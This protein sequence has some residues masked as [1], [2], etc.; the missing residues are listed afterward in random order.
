MIV[1]Q[2]LLSITPRLH[3]YHV[4]LGLL[5]FLMRHVS[6]ALTQQTV[7][8][9][10]AMSTGSMTMEILITDARLDVRRWPVVLATRALIRTRARLS[11]AM[12]T[13]LTTMAILILVARLVVRRLLMVLVTLVLTRTRARL[14]P[15]LSISLMTTGIFTTDAK[16]VVLHWQMPLA[17]PARQMTPVDAQPSHATPIISILTE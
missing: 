6:G 17:Q 10:L 8:C 12:P 3:A 16:W 9:L 1:P 2:V 14:S 7:Q 11:P 4:R 13:S 5:F 15:A